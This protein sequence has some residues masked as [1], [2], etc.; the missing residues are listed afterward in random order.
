M[1]RDAHRRRSDRGVRHQRRRLARLC[2][3]RLARGAR[4]PS[5]PESAASAGRLDPSGG[6]AREHV[7]ERRHRAVP[8]HLPAQRP[9]ALARRCR[10][11]R[12]QRFASCVRLGLCRRRARGPAG[13]SRRAQRRTGDRRRR[14]CPLPLDSRDLAGLRLESP[15]RGRHR[16]VLAQPIHV[17]QLA[18]A[19]ATSSRGLRPT[20]DDDERGFRARRARRRRH[21]SHGRPEHVHVSLPAQ[22]RDLPRVRR[23]AAIRAVDA[24]SGGAACART[25]RGCRT[26]SHLHLLRHP[27]RDPD[28]RRHRRDERAPPSVRQE[29]RTR[30]RARDRRDLVCLLG[31]GCDR[32]SCR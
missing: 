3:V 1:S 19:A 13:P 4:L 27:Q 14:L 31:R 12:C 9:R 22:C 10:P 7:R 21:R 28:R 23:S 2:T 30:E 6:R 29:H 20:A 17:A 5:Q 11:R 26:E 15:R 25:L 18:D 24:P 16:V 32:R 8:D